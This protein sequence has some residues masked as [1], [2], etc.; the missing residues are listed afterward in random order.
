MAILEA[1]YDVSE[2]KLLL[3]GERPGE[4]PLTLPDMPGP[5]SLQLVKALD[6]TQITIL[7]SKQEDQDEAK[8]QAGIWSKLLGFE[9]PVLFDGWTLPEEDLLAVLRLNKT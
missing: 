7:H 6:L 4:N 8:R 9:V 1:K 2:K 3:Y 5:R